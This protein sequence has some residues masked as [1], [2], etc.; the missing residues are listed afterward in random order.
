[1][2]VT[3]RFDAIDKIGR[4]LQRRFG[5]TEIDIYLDQFGVSPPAPDSVGVNSKWVYSKVALKSAPLSTIARIADDLGIGS[6]AQL[7]AQANPP[8]LWKGTSDL[9]LFVSHISKDKIKATRLRDCLK[10]YGI[11]AF[12]AHE[13]IEPTREWQSEIERALFAMDAMVAMHT[14]GFSKSIWTQQEI[15]FAL[16]RGVKT[17]SLRMGEDPTGFISKHQ[18][19]S[20]GA[21]SAEDVA[22]ELADIFSQDERTAKR[23][24]EAKS[25]ML[26]EI[27][28]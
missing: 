6:L 4:E 16:G 2:K 7:A 25:R 28:F 27:P 3:D 11:Q 12:V 21:K 1:M 8:T 13:D 18:A 22:K 19:L 24:Q 5:F 17:V 20:R 10:Q 14:P 9:R 26:D 23:L 15:G